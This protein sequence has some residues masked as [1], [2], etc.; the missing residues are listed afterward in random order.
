MWKLAGER[1]ESRLFLG[2][3]RFPSPAILKEAI[4]ASRTQ[5]VTVSLRRLSPTQKKEGGGG[6]EGYWDIIRSCG[7]RLLPN[8]AGCRSAKEAVTTAQ[9]ARELFATHWIK[10]EVIGDEET[11]Q[12]DPFGLLEAAR[13][14]TS[15]GFEVFPYTTEDIVVAERLLHVGC[16]ILMPLGSPIGTGRGLTN[17]LALKTLRNRF[18]NTT[19]ILDAGIGLPSHASAAM[20]IGFD[21][22]LLNTAVALA[23]KPP[24]MA[25]SFALA[26]EAGRR[27]FEA[28]L[29]L[30]REH[31]EPSTPVLG[32]PFWH[33]EKS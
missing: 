18:P 13:I 2:T 4:Q 22:V 17:V 33:E 1:M 12:P 24:Q 9:L 6:G 10:L 14:L 25:A 27:G 20:E 5:I 15:E 16:R 26:V 21:G 31:A 7:V 29:M 28:G 3:A 19:L 32:V 23:E 30:P 11:L 8:T